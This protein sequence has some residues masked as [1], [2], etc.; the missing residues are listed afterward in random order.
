[1]LHPSTRMEYHSLRGQ[2]ARPQHVIFIGSGP[3]PLSSLTLAS[4]HLVKFW[5]NG[6]WSILNVDV[7]PQANELGSVFTAKMFPNLKSN[8]TFV[9]CEAAEIDPAAIHKADVIYLAALVVSR[10][11]FDC[12]YAG[13]G[14]TVMRQFFHRASICRP[15]KTSSL[16]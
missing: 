14:L 4:Q 11:S 1:M 16:V 10:L 6:N 3:L 12:L 5:I 13:V 15:S 2:G 9:T 7:C 8:M